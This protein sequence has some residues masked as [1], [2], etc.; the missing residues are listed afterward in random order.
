[1]KMKTFLLAGLAALA[2]TSATAAD[3]AV[4]ARPMAAPV[5]GCGYNAITLSNNQIS[6][7]YAGINKNY[8]EY[9]PA[10]LFN[11][12]ALPV[13]AVIDSENGW[14]HG[15]SVTGSAMFNLGAFCN[16]YV[17]GRGSYFDGSTDYWQPLGRLSGQSNAKIWEGDFRF[18]KGFD[19][20]PNFMLT[21]YL[22][23]G[24]RSWDRDLCQGGAC[25]GGG[26][27]ENYRH[28]YVGA[29]LMAQ[30]AMTPALVLTAS[31]LIGG[32]FDSTLTGGPLANGN[33]TIIPFR[34]GLGNSTIYKIEGA[35]DYAFTQNFHGNIGVEYTEFRYGLSAPFVTDN[36]GN[37]AV[38]PDSR[39]RN[40]TV[41]A[42]LGW[43]FGPAP[44]VAKY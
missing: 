34:T 22:G 25:F 27:H 5:A 39:T 38:E 24:A 9:N 44:V 14:V 1:M 23:V 10:G 15:V 6:L 3:M 30:Y 2:A 31:G 26:F 42:G 19:L 11:D 18:G 28:S 20:T 8:E 40:V 41:R 29:G 37:P 43:A 13:G 7:Q 35:L 33:P 17:F 36:L 21:P 32:T 12:P 4:K 16:L